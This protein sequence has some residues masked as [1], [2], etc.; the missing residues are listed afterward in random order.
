MKNTRDSVNKMENYKIKSKH[1]N[2]IELMDVPFLMI[3]GF[4]LYEIIEFVSVSI[5]GRTIP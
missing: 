1:S 4:A 2:K 3:S 5:L